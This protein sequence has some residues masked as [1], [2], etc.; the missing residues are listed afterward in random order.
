M[1]HP[2]L[3]EINTRCWLRELSEKHH[4]TITLAEIPEEEFTRW[5]RL[6]FTHIWLMGVWTTGEGAREI[7]LNVPDL[8][9]AY[10]EVL[11][12]WTEADVAG[13]PYSIADYSV[14]KALGGDEGLKHFR[15]KLKLHGLKLILDF[16]PN[17]LGVDHPW[18][19]ERPEMFVQSPVAVDGT[20][21][22]P[23][24]AGERWIAH[25]KDPYFPGWTDTAQVDYRRPGARQAMQELLLS[26][27]AKCDG[28]RCDMAMLLL[29]EVMA[30][31]WAH[32]PSP[33]PPLASEF[34]SD[35]IPVVKAAQPGFLFMAEVYWG[36]E[37]KLQSLGFDYTYDKALYDDLIWRNAGEAQRKLL[38]H[39]AEYVARSVHFLENHDEHRVAE[40]LSPA[41]NRAAALVIL[42][43]PGMR[44]L[45]EGQLTG[46]K[47]KLP[48][49]LGRRQ[50]EAPQP[51]V[52]EAYEKLL[53][54]LKRSAVGQG[55]G[56]ILAPGAAWEGN[57]TSQ[58]FIVVQW[59]SKAPRFDLVVVNLAP[60]RSQCYVPLDVPELAEH[61][62]TMTDL[63]GTERYERVGSDIA[64]YGLYLDL[65]PHGAQVF[66][67]EP[68]G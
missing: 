52:Q 57:P 38:T 42:G 45:H 47:L 48:V 28:V 59:Q 46:A 14:P 19:R 49:Q 34:W 9:C 36:L 4:R 1:E 2:L 67:F 11:P 30:R 54:T 44:F 60:H 8:R 33:E 23:T 22:V 29:N 6:G 26:I 20:F 63:L 61:H 41:E 65:P 68:K 66:H 24:S 12:G 40:K 16:V 50:I 62:W 35:A 5:L 13:S 64:E 18:V 58:N 3:Y 25:G 53:T 27:A 31:T 43:L 17:H 10:D 21:G 55:V 37:G 32:L 56:R 15:A 51:E 7:A 39:S